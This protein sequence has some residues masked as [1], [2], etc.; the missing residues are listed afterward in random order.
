MASEVYKELFSVKPGAAEIETSGTPA[1]GKAWI[2]SRLNICNDSGSGGADDTFSILS[3]SG[4]YL[5]TD[6]TMTK[7]QHDKWN[8]LVLAA[9]EELSFTSAGGKIRFVGYG[10]EVTY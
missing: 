3:S 5:A 6:E 8:G 1:T 7:Q 2:L 9:G 10:A 4:G